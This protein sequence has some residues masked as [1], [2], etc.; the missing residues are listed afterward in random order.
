MT[1]VFVDDKFIERRAP[2]QRS[3]MALQLPSARE[4]ST[5]HM[6]VTAPF[7]LP[8]HGTTPLTGRVITTNHKTGTVLAKCLVHVLT[9]AGIK[10]VRADIHTWG[11]TSTSSPDVR[12]IN[13][14]RNPFVLVH[15]GYMYHRGTSSAEAWTVVPFRRMGAR[16]SSYT[17]ESSGYWQGAFDAHRSFRTCSNVTISDDSTYRS[18]L[19]TLALTDGLLLECLRALHRDIPY[20]VASALACYHARESTK[21]LSAPKGRCGNVLLEDV[22]VDFRRGFA[23]YLAVPLNISEALGAPVAQMCYQPNSSH[24]SDH[25]ERAMAV[26][27][28][29]EIDT[30]YLDGAL[31]RAEETLLR[32]L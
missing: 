30:R 23:Q 4:V 12:Q 2:H 17:T 27:L 32:L 3:I 21:S 28:I 20:M 19:N 1:L 8:H 6:E 10:L 7:I 14:V 29:R 18:A 15:S 13:L 22:M 26:E 24:A 25:S 11:F 16:Y 9:Q 5:C 31:H